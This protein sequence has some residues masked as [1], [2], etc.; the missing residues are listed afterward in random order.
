MSFS[1]V[2]SSEK[3]FLCEPCKV[4]CSD[5][6]TYQA[7]LLSFE[8]KIKEIRTDVDRDQKLVSKKGSSFWCDLCQ[9]MPIFNVPYFTKIIL[10]LWVQP[11]FLGLVYKLGYDGEP[12]Q[13]ETAPEKEES[14]Q[15]RLR[16]QATANSRK[17]TYSVQPSSW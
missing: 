8:H 2:K 3:S 6:A 10:P 14:S 16:N 13:R 12:S 1:A 9:G 7:H 11:F 15:P 17:A 4:Q 5:E